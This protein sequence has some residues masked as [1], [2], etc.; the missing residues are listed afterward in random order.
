MIAIQSF[1]ILF[2]PAIRESGSQKKRVV[3]KGNADVQNG[4]IV[5]GLY[6]YTNQSFNHLAIKPL[7]TRSAVTI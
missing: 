6:G 3:I 2:I 7:T 5:K 4:W 1:H